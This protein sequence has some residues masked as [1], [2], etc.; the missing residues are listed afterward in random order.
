MAIIY[1]CIRIYICVCIYAFNL[2]WIIGKYQY[3]IE[4]I[5]F[6][7]LIYFTQCVYFRCFSCDTPRDLQQHAH[8]C[9]PRNLNMY[10]N[11]AIIFTIPG[12]EL[13]LG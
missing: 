9:Y 12:S 7:L 5:H 3:N 1:G 6:T 13:C 2:E 8:D 4:F 10:F 11:N